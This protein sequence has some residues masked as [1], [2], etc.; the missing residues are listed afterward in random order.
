MSPAAINFFG[1]MARAPMVRLALPFAAGIA[2]A[3]T[4]LFP[5]WSALALLVVTTVPVVAILLRRTVFEQR[6][7][8]GMAVSS[9]FLVFGICWAAVRDPLAKPTHVSVDGAAVEERILHLTAINGISA[10]VVRADARVVAAM[11]DGELRP[12]TG[13]IML[14]LMRREGTADPVAGDELVVR[15]GVEPI[16]RV[17]DPGGFDRRSWAASRGMYHEAFAG[18][19]QWAVIGHAWRWTDLFEPTRQR[20]S[21]WL[22][23]SGLPDRER[24]LVKA[25]VLG[26]RDELDSDQREAFV[27]SGTIHVLAVSGTHVGFIYVMLLFMTKW[28]GHTGRAR[29]VR[30]VLILLALWG[31]AGLTGA[32]PSV[33]RATIMFSLFTIAGMT[34]RQ[35]EPLNSLF[36]AALL[37]LLWEPHMLVEIG[38]QLSFL[39][40]LGIILFYKPLFRAWMPHNA[41]VGHLW[42]LAALSLAAQTF[43]TPLSLY[44]FNAFP[45][46]FLPANLI[47]VT[48]AGIAVY[49]AVA[50]LVLFR[51][52]VLGPLVVL[53]LTALLRIVDAVTNFFAG[54]PL[55]YPSI[56]VTL[57]DGLLL[58][59]LVLLV[60]IGLMWQWRSAWRYVLVVIVL[61]LVGWGHRAQQAHERVTFSVYDDRHALQAAM[62]VGRELMVYAPDTSQGS[63]WVRMKVERHVRALGLT[64]RSLLGDDAL[65]G[66][67]VRTESGTILGGGLWSTPG[68]DVRFHT[69]SSATS[70]I[71][72]SDVL[73]LHDIQFIEKDDLE[74]LTGSS[75]YIV[76]AG[77]LPWKLRAHVRKWCAERDIPCHDVT[78]QGAFQLEGLRS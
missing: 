57:W 15:S 20:V 74:V 26:L 54:L 51:V 8:R 68:L 31:Y 67:G 9:W 63:D 23:E 21:S 52:P 38:F 45:V 41:I 62:R 3:R 32:C 58:Y 14:T 61:I 1:V 47:V 78:E 42:S 28:W 76:L 40:V 64:P 48:A 46:W 71:I 16:T 34:E 55:A 33:L 72:P 53:L 11:V 66:A 2:L 49:G 37:L 18:P 59:A 39:A 44:L 27:H 60:A 25:L 73:V 35:N 4:G 19:G 69:S 12:R 13:T 30:G 77:G 65:R 17:P 10:K 6:W 22:A 50:L 5:L 56:R 43:T 75:G 70:V 29:R 36:A 7:V 24:A